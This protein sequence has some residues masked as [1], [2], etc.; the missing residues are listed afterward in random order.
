[1][2]NKNPL[3]EKYY[4]GETSLEEE[5]LLKS[6]ILSDE[7]TTDELYTSLLFNAF[8]DEKKEEAPPSIKTLLFLSQKSKKNDFNLKKWISIATAAAACL[9]IVFTLFHYNKKQEYEAFVIINGIRINDEKLA[10]Q[11]I[12]ESF[13]EEE[14]IIQLGLAQLSEMEKIEN[15]LNEIANNIINNY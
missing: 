6:T 4:K 5:N 2:K 9:A 11:Y 8:S 12:K 7:K 10:L 15:E 14:R 13:E 1:M 3:L